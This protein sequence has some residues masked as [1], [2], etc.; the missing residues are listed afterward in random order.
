MYNFPTGVTFSPQHAALNNATFTGAGAI[1]VPAGTSWT[2]SFPTVQNLGA[3]TVS[4]GA[5][6]AVDSFASFS[7]VSVTN[8]GL[9]TVT[10]NSAQ[11][12]LTNGTHFTNA[13][14]GEVRF[15]GLTTGGGF[16][17]SS[18]ATFT[19]NGLLRNASSAGTFS[20]FGITFSNPGTLGNGRRDVHHLRYA[21]AGF[22]GPDH[23]DRR[24]LAGARRDAQD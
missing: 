19:N 3:F 9:I 21:P 2:A 15:V 17:N 20:I 13:A 18:T 22:R 1:V 6:L 10:A 8:H 23:A 16:L 11:L 4:S 12:T 14:D 7:N 5:A 24:Y